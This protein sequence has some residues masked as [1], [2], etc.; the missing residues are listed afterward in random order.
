MSKDLRTTIIVDYQNVH[1]TGHGLFGSTRPLPPHETLVDPLLFGLHL[2]RA[3]NARQQAGMARAVLRRVLV[4]RGQPSPDHDS[5]GYARNLAQKAHWE[6]DPRVQVTLRP[7][8]YE[9]L[10]D[11]AGIYATDSHGK[12]IVSGKPREKGVDVLVKSAG[13]V[14]EV[15]PSVGRVAQAVMAWSGRSVGTSSVVLTAWARART[16]SPR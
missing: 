5:A 16:S 9:Y 10:K 1:L 8:K 2:V 7:L 12:R 11:A 15:D 4:Y 14:Y 13:V 3:R 6:R